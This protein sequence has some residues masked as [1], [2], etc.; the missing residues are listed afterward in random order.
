MPSAL[1]FARDASLAIARRLLAERAVVAPVFQGVHEGYAHLALFQREFP[2]LLRDL[3]KDFRAIEVGAG[4]GWHAAL[5]AAH[6]GG[7][8]L[9]TEVAWRPGNTPD[10][11]ANAH[12]F[13]RLA[14]RD[15]VLA[16]FLEFERDAAGSLVTTKFRGR[17][18][19]AEGGAEALP[20]ADESADFV[21]SVN[22]VEHIP[23]LPAAFRESARVLRPGGILFATTEPLYASAFGSH[24]FDVFP[25]PWAH[26]LWPADELAEIVER[27]VGAGRTWAPGVPL[28][29][30]VVKREILG[31]LNHA[32]PAEIRGLLLSGPWRVEG[33]VDHALPEHRA[34]AAEMR[35]RDALPDRAEDDLFLVGLTMKLRKVPA[36]TPRGLRL[37]L[38]LPWSLRRRLGRA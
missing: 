18:T 14:A 8:V 15:K 24:L 9:A 2:Q 13:H 29:A 11:V 38:R 26:L 1:Q 4:M 10:S 28:T 27:E 22:C 36:G 33:W 21:Y 17:V 7:S 20:A 23:D 31:T 6:G 34:F 5:T 12:A 32:R 16:D 3:P 35:L 37:A 25:A 19:F 30:A